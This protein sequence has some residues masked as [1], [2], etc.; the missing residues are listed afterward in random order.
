MSFK[1]SRMFK[2]A[3]CM[4]ACL[5]IAFSSLSGYAV[6]ISARGAFVLDSG[7]GEAL[8]VHNADTAIPPASMT[9]IV[10]LYVIYSHL[11]DG[12]LTKDTQIPVGR[13]LAAYSRD[14]GYSNV[15]L[16]AGQTYSVDELLGAIC[17][18]SAN[19]AVMAIG[20][21][22]C[23]S[24][25]GFVAEM[26]SLISGWGVNGYF[27]DCTGVSS[28][29]R[30]SPRG[31]ATVA[32]RLITDYPDVLNYTSLTFLNFRGQTY[33]PTNKMLPGGA[34]EYDGT[35]GLKTGTTSAAG[36][37]FTG[38]AVRNGK[39]LISVVMGESST[40]MRYVDTIK[41]MDYSWD[42]LSQRTVEPAY[43]DNTEKD[44][45]VATDLRCFINDWEIPTYIHYGNAD[46][47]YQ[48]CAV[49]MINDLPDYGFDV[50]YDEA[51]DTVTIVNN[52]DKD[53]TA[54]PNYGEQTWYDDMTKLQLSD[55]EPAKILL[56]N[57]VDDPGVY[58]EQTFDINGSGAISIDELWHMGTVV[59]N[60]KYNLTVVVTRY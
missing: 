29:N 9:K 40:N 17:V 44:Y 60:E 34:Y 45:I 36:C 10:S 50:S 5:T 11:A 51:S 53:L 55:W 12:S 59:W 22:L 18:V 54:G 15:Y 42:L 4:L 2:A 21:Y 24:E 46:N 52:T 28:S 57:G 43:T 31:M 58:A 56:K 19:A 23:G 7:T 26:N 14:P 41:I 32:N 39:R 33:Y 8:F 49:V 27:V 6:S 37:C 3:V 16:T 35:D 25:A 48:D 20:D 30:I 1:K 47:G 38:T 13:A